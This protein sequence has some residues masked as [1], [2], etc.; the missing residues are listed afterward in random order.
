[1]VLVSPSI[2]RAIVRRVL[3]SSYKVFNPVK[4]VLSWPLLSG[5]LPKSRKSFP[6]ITVKLT[7]IMKAVPCIKPSTLLSG[8][9]HLFR[10]PNEWFFIVFTSIKRSL[11]EDVPYYC[12]RSH[13]VWHQV[14][15]NFF[16]FGPRRRR[17]R[18]ASICR[19]IDIS[20]FDYL[21]FLE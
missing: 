18:W 19:G 16:S 21:H 6:L 7:C 12:N 17:N 13:C 15:F 2:K 9:G 14:V 1:M 10:A 3:L 8:R 5:H 11:S 20:V 4:P